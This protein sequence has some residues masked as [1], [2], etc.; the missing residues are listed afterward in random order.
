MRSPPDGKGLDAGQQLQPHQKRVLCRIRVRTGIFAA[1]DIASC[2]S[3]PLVRNS[4]PELHIPRRWLR[5]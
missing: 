5:L 2:I 4:R 3:I 1:V